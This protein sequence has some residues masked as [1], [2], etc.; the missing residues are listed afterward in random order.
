MPSL[1]AH[2]PR[3]N[4]NRQR[5]PPAQPPPVP[6]TGS[7]AEGTTRAELFEGTAVLEVLRPE[8]SSYYWTSY[9]VD[10]GRIIGVQ[11][12]KFGTGQ[13]YFLPADLS[14]CDRPD[15]TFRQR[16]CK[17]AQALEQ[18]LVAVEAES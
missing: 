15:C 3:V 18:A 12:R 6:V 1:T 2:G 9:V 17:H 13:V 5:K 16:R 8:D 11:L 10:A 7:F 4:V 14:E